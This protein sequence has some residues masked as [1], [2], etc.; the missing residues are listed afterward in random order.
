MAVGSLRTVRVR[1]RRSG[2]PSRPEH[3]PPTARSIRV[4][5]TEVRDQLRQRLQ[6]H[7]YNA[8]FSTFLY[9]N[10]IDNERVHRCCKHFKS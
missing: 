10:Q 9:F 7:P 8:L 1:R 6:Q 5:P 4:N 2:G 3:G